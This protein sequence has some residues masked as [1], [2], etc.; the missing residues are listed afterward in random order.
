VSSVGN[1]IGIVT[2]SLSDIITLRATGA[3]PQNVN[4]AIKSSYVL[5]LLESEHEL[6]GKLKE[7]QPSKE[8]KFEDVVKEAQEAAALVLVY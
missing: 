8:R 6:A 1:V 3:L 4:Y 7:P 5:S 2:A